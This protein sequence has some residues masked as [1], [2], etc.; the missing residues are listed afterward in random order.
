VVDT[1]AAQHAGGTTRTI[2]VAFGLTGLYLALEK[3]YTGRQVQRAHMQIAKIQKDWPRLQPP[4][5]PA[6]CTVLDVLH[7]PEGPKRDRM[8]RQWMAAVWESWADRQ[9]WVRE[10]TDALMRR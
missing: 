2:T 10:T 3:G 6:E 5:M 8:I 9:E 1:Y 7:A 4:A